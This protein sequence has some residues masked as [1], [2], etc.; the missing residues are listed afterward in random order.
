LAGNQVGAPEGAA[1]TS[2]TRASSAPS[3]YSSW[4][5]PVA[6][7]PS[8]RAIQGSTSAPSATRVALRGRRASDAIQGSRSGGCGATR[9][10]AAP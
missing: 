6:L 1:P 5:G 10:S 4:S 3:S 9:R 8:W 7:L 2:S